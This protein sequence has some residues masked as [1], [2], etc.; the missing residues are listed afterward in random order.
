MKFKNIRKTS[1]GFGGFDESYDVAEVVFLGVPLKTTDFPHPSVV[2]APTEIRKASLEL[3]S[4]I[5]PGPDTF[6]ALSISDLGDLDLSQ[7][8]REARN[9]VTG[10]VR[11]I[12]DD[13]KI[14]ALLGGEHTL[15]EF[16]TSVLDDPFVLYLDAH[17]DLRESYREKRFPMGR[18]LAGFLIT[19]PL[20]NSFKLGFGPARGRRRNSPQKR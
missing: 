4:F 10:V 20:R 14:L 12:L 13:E 9:Q 6:E 18:W 3:E 7:D 19:F 5:M 1:Q 8:I 11:E 16:V 2:D 15:S 17:R